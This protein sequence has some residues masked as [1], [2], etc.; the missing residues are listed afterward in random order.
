M[1]LFFSTPVWAS[2]VDNY[3]DVNINILDY[4]LKLQNKDPTGIV[5]SNLKGW[6]S[7]F[8]PPEGS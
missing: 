5:K 6:H 2:K 4:I 8:V 3:N 1:H 7:I